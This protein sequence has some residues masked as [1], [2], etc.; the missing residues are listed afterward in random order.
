MAYIMWLPVWCYPDT[1][2]CPVGSRAHT[3]DCIIIDFLCNCM[4]VFSSVVLECCYFCFFTNGTFYCL[5]CTSPTIHL[6]LDLTI[7]TIK[8]AN[9][10]SESSA[11]WAPLTVQKRR[12]TKS[13]WSVC[14]CINLYAFIRSCEYKNVC[15]WER[16]LMGVGHQRWQTH[17]Q[18]VTTSTL[19]L[20][21]FTDPM[22][23]GNPLPCRPFI[24]LCKH[25]KLKRKKPNPC[26]NISQATQRHSRAACC[27]LAPW[28]ILNPSRELVPSPVVLI[29][30]ISVSCMCSA[31]TLNLH[32]CKT[33]H[34]LKTLC[35]KF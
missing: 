29:E 15:V 10:Y 9:S 6:S 17:S 23:L 19:Q 27:P 2:L 8:Q 3:R 18:N 13:L 31:I 1:Q 34:H 25:W 5:S 4:A 7:F 24:R 14:W 32:I 30:L 21:H 26:A 33:T 22:L 16:E 11:A 20:F 35:S 12:E 28:L